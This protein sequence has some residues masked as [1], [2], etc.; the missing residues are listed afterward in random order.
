MGKRVILVDGDLRQP[1]QH[2]IFGLPNDRGLTTAL[3]APAT[4]TRAAELPLQESGVDGLRLLSSGPPVELPSELLASPAMGA[5]IAQLRDAADIVLFDAPPVVS[6]TD[7]AELA[8]KMDGVL[9]VAAAGRTRRDQAEQALAMLNRVG[10]R[11]V[12]AT[13][14]NVPATSRTTPAIVA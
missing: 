13:L 14:I 3:R 12:G 1:A 4:S 6:A 11:V 9:L 7:A 5:V 10:A 2:L 8:G